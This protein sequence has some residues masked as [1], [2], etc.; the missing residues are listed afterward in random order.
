MSP[1]LHLTSKINLS[2]SSSHVS[3]PPSFLEMP[4]PVDVSLIFGM[5]PTALRLP[6]KTTSERQKVLQSHHLFTLLT[7]HNGKHFF[8]MSPSKSGT[9]PS[10]AFG[11]LTW[12][13]AS[14]QWLA[15]FHLSSAHMAPPLPLWRAYFSTLLSRESLEKHK[16]ARLSCII[17]HLGLL[18]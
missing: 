9:I 3:R 17:A 16:P 5:V 6:R 4:K 12:T 1:V 15:T 14:P 13:C 10:S 2:R 18:F 11:T 8:N 7:R